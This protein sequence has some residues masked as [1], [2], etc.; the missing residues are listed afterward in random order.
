VSELRRDASVF[1]NYEADG[2]TTGKAAGGREK[3]GHGKEYMV[4]AVA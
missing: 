1:E 3:D 4:T 2:K